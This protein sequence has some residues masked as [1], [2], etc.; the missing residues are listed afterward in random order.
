MLSLDLQ[1]FAIQIFPQPDNFGNDAFCH[2]VILNN[3][4][5]FLQSANCSSLLPL[6]QKCGEQS[7]H[8]H[9]AALDFTHDG[10][11]TRLKGPKLCTAFAYI[12]YSIPLTI[13]D[14]SSFETEGKY[15]NCFVQEAG[16]HKV[17]ERHRQQKE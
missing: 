5:D 6:V 3:C 16:E 8:Y 13:L 2:S 11:S 10:T 17:E 12:S 14:N 4:F 15:P 7:L 1:H 9:H